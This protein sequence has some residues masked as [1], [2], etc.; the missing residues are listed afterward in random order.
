MKHINIEENPEAL[1]IKDLI[2]NIRILESKRKDIDAQIKAHKEQL[3]QR[4][5]ETEDKKFKDEEYEAYLKEVKTETI[6]KQWVKKFCEE[7]GIN[8]PKK[9]SVY[10]RLYYKRF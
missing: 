6:D 5:Q 10:T 8:Y 9:E 1:D 7:Q 2:K 4:L 3:T